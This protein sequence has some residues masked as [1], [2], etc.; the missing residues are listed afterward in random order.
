MS[1]LVSLLNENTKIVVDVDLGGRITEFSLNGKNALAEQGIQVGSTFWPSPQSTWDWPPLTALDS[2]AYQLESESDSCVQMISSVCESTQLQLRKII[3]KTGRGFDVTYELINRSRKPVKYAPWE[4]SRVYGGLTLFES[5]QPILDNSNLTVD[6]IQ[7]HYWFDYVPAGL[8]NNLKLFA[9]HSEGWI[10][11]VFNGLL[12]LK[13]FPKIDQD[14]IAP[15]EAEVEVY[16]HGDPDN[17]YIEIEQQGAYVEIQAGSSIKWTVGWS[18]YS[19]PG[20]VASQES[21]VGSQALLDFIHANL[22]KT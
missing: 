19:L 3:S 7:D 17:A 18:L 20:G 6:H 12:Y 9:N 8:E 1:K 10:A 5:S 22:A 2:D 21:L 15:N 14:L 4:I 11:N 16:A 13:T